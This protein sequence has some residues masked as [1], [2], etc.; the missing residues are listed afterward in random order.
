MSM[1]RG[2]KSSPPGI[3]TLARPYR[4]SR[5]PEHHHRG[6]HLLDQLVGRLGDERRPGL[7]TTSSSGV[8]PRCTSTPMAPS[9]SAMMSTSVMRGTLVSTWRPSA[10]RQA[11]ISL[12]TEF[13]APP[14]RTVPCSGPLGLTTKRSTPSVW[15]GPPRHHVDGTLGHRAERPAPTRSDD[16]PLLPAAEDAGQGVDDL[17][18][19][20]VG[21]HGVED[22]RHQVARRDAPHRPPAGPGPPRPPRSDAVVPDLGQPLALGLVD[23]GP[24]VE[25]GQFGLLVA[26]GEVVDPDDD[27]SRRSETLR[28]NR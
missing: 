2:P 1:G 20:G 14:A 22:G 27:R 6:P 28:W 3:D 5:R 17:A 10:S 13:L 25:G 18:H 7:V 4:A 9:T 12:S 16:G 26:L 23:L 8:R 11:A 15:P 21:A 19:R 24:D